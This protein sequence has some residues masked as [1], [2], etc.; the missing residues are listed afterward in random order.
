HGDKEIAMLA[1][2]GARMSLAHDADS[3]TVMQPRWNRERQHFGAHV[4][5]PPAAN[6]AACVGLDARAAATRAGLRKH[7]VPARRL[8]DASAL[9][10]AAPP[11]HGRQA[12]EAAARPAVFLPRDGH[13]VRSTAY[14]FVERERDR[15]VK[16]GATFGRLTLRRSPPMEDVGKQVAEG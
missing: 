5:L 9:A 4:D 6:R 3:R 11:L 15:L 16:V 12:P 8:D 7:H 10:R 13:F 2:V 14:G 1:R